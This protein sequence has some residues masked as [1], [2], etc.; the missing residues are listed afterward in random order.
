MP[1]SEKSASFSAI[2]VP[3]SLGIAVIPTETAVEEAVS[4]RTLCTLLSSDCR[5]PD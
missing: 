1:Y 2:G 3:M 4:R 5:M